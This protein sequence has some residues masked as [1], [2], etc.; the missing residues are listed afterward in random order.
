MFMLGDIF[1]S[2]AL[3]SIFPLLVEKCWIS[4][5]HFL[6]GYGQLWVQCYPL[7]TQDSPSH[8]VKGIAG[9]FVVCV[10]DF[11]GWKHCLLIGVLCLWGKEKSVT[12]KEYMRMGYWVLK[13]WACHS[14]RSY[15][16]EKT[17]KINSSSLLSLL[18]L[19]C[20]FHKSISF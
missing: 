3:T 11:Q 1:L 2:R 15:E 5:S 8:G 20:T 7:T 16:K 12:V 9:F 4:F 14:E 13:K 18:L 10:S 6:L 17:W 19:F